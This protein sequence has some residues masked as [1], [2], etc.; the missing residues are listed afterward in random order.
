MAFTPLNALTGFLAVA[1]H[2]NFAA[3]AAELRISP[4]ALSQSVRQ[5]E[6][7]L[8]VPLLT[9]T[10]RSVAL[11]ETGRRLLEHAGPG[12]H[13]ALEA[14][15][16]A[17]A[18]TGELTGKVRL[19]VPEISVSSVIAP[20]LPRF[21]ARHPQV[22]VEIQV[23]SQRVDIVREGFDAGIR[24]EEFLERDMVQVRLTEAFRFVV[25]G[26]PSYLERQ[27]TPKKPEELL[28]HE[29]IGY[30]AP[31]GKLFSWDLE[32]GRKS[33]RVPV[34]GRVTTNDAT[35]MLDLA[36]AGVGLTYATEPHVLP[37]LA[38]GG[39]RLVLEPYAAWVP[40]LF[41]YFPHR[42][43]VSPAFR[44]FLDIAREVSA[45]QRAR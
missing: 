32:R 13:Q 11:T 36:E 35:V 4:S 15:K 31:T 28:Q 9:R 17:S 19:T 20:V 42:A 7:R 5:L 12:I 29:C 2:R 18:R 16:A 27:G 25:V 23:Q 3:A 24:L 22:E 26:A 44:A 33:W 38:R 14:L 37:R 21:L 45:E 8:G 41:L 34:R 30:R 6:T 10:T 1:R 40:G 43:R 39:L